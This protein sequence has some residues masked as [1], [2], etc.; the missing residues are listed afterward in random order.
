MDSA[1]ARL[2][3]EHWGRRCKCKFLLDIGN[4]LARHRTE[5]RKTFRICMH[6]PDLQGF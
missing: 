6:A 2:T 3:I 1:S 5:C 4:K